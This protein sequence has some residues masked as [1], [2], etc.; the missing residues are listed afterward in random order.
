MERAIIHI[1]KD[2]L[3]PIGLVI[4]VLSSVF[5]ATWFISALNSKVENQESRIANL[6]KTVID[7][8]TIKQDVSAMKTDLQWIKS[9][10]S[11]AEIVQ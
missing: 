6:E 7:I 10:L 4:V 9:T 3:V 2:T 11:N 5:T 8:S 1:D